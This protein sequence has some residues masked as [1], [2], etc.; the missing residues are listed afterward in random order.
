MRFFLLG[1]GLLSSR[2]EFLGPLGCTLVPGSLEECETLF[3]HSK[4]GFRWPLP[5][6]RGVDGDGIDRGLRRRA[7]LSL[8]VG[9]CVEAT[10]RGLSLGFRSLLQRRDQIVFKDP[11][12]RRFP[13]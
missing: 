8:L 12:Q 9:E 13:A 2:C 11:L 1:V 10:A 5:N 3:L 7:G 6:G 4:V